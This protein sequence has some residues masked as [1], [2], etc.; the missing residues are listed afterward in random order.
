MRWCSLLFF[1]TLIFFSR[2]CFAGPKEAAQ[3]KE[4][5]D[6]AMDAHHYDEA[7]DLYTQAYAADANPAFLYNRG[8]AHEARS[9][10][11]D[12]LD[13]MEKFGQLAS[14]DL[15]ARVPKL[16]EL[17]ADLRARIAVLEIAC[18]VDGARVIV[19]GKLIG[20]TPLPKT[21]LN[22][23]TTILEVIGVDQ[24]PYQKEIKLE[25]GVTMH[26]DVQLQSS[27]ASIGT[28]I[29]KTVPTGATILVDDKPFGSS[30]TEG[31]LPAGNHRVLAR[32]QEYEDAVSQAV[33]EAE[34]RKEIELSLKHHSSSIFASPV[35]WTIVGVV[36]AGGVIAVTAALVSERSADSGMGFMPDRVRGP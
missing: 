11:A 5:A 12:A 33:V 7:V 1:F 9:E 26:L 34:H 28:L 18:N 19:G 8:R 31:V 32:M 6:A 13:D 17:V 3:L 20:T 29:V 16:A 14:P 2:V 21:R 27:K 4:R 25:G 36:V 35:F 15:R 23:G 22:A 30:P 10:Y 24:I